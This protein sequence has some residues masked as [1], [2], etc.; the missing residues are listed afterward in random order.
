MMMK[1]GC[2][3][4]AGQ[5]L[6]SKRLWKWIMKCIKCINVSMESTTGKL[7]H[8]TTLSNQDLKVL[9]TDLKVN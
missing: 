1:T 2:T 6:K 9:Y 8:N 4:A 5:S 3:H 7:H